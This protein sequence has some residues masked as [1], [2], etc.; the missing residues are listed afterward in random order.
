ML[1]GIPGFFAIWLTLPFTIVPSGEVPSCMATMFGVV[2]FPGSNC[3]DDALHV[4]GRVLAGKFQTLDGDA[5]EFASGRGRSQFSNSAF[6]FSPT[7][8]LTVPYSTLGFGVVV[9]PTENVVITSVLFN[10]ADSS[11]TT[12]FD[13]IGDGWTWSTEATFQYRLGDLPGGQVV[14]FI[15][16]ADSEF[17]SFS[18]TDLVPGA[19][20]VSTE[21]DSWALTWSAWQYLYT[22]D[23]VPDRI[24]TGDGR[25]DLRGIGL[26]ARAGI[27]DDDT[28]PIDLTISVG[29]GGRG[30]IPGRDDD[31][32]GLGFGYSDFD[33][34]PVLAA[35]GF[36]DNAYALEAFYLFDF[37]HGL[38]LTLGAQVLEPFSKTVD[39]TTILGARFNV[40]F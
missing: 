6:V 10:T 4:V 32:Y 36:D 5:N 17:L 30:L 39:T 38:S 3:D 8:M 37:G 9:I 34:G 40:R 24:N 28:N 29:V 22:P 25:A 1:V 35:A 12:G 7:T 15:Y 23:E 27:A 26:F 18:R 2:R 21:N 33:T 31:N 13:D 14:S 19:P 11:T 20:L 16:A